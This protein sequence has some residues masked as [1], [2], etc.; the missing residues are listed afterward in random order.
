MEVPYFAS[1]LPAWLIVEVEYILGFGFAPSFGVTFHNGQVEVVQ[2]QKR[3]CSC[4][5]DCVAVMVVQLHRWR[6]WWIIVSPT[7][8]LLNP[9]HLGRPPDDAPPKL[10]FHPSRFIGH[11]RQIQYNTIQIHKYIKNTRTQIQAIAGP[12]LPN[13]N[14]APPLSSSNRTVWQRSLADLIVIHVLIDALLMHCNK[15]G[16]IW[17]YNCNVFTG[18]KAQKWL[19]E[20]RNAIEYFSVNS[21]FTMQYIA[22]WSR[23]AGDDRTHRK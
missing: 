13:L 10:K 22:M 20:K 1:L 3:L 7:I 5:G 11:V 4:T 15:V 17:F 9:P 8:C 21:T 2:L 14:V 6:W 12:G 19:H 18:R 23:G 16:A